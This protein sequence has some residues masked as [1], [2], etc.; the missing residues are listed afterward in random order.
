MTPA[1]AQ[2]FAAIA[3]KTR[4]ASYPATLT[5]SGVT[6]ALT[7]AKSPTEVRRE[8][9]PMGGGWFQEAR[10]FIVFPS[11]GTYV[12]AIGAK[13]TLVTCDQAAEVGTVW[14]VRELTRG[15]ATLGTGHGCRCV[16]MD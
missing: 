16:R 15:S 12:P 13:F 7:V 1:A 3:T 4:A 8:A 2:R 6:G 14:S 9:D 10:C 5:V 11:T